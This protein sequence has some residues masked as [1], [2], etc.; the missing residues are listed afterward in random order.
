M[1]HLVEQKLLPRVCLTYAE[2]DL[3]LAR[4]YDKTG[5]EPKFLVRL[6]FEGN[7]TMPNGGRFHG[8]RGNFQVTRAGQIIRGVSGGI[9]PDSAGLDPGAKWDDDTQVTVE[10]PAFELAM[11]DTAAQIVHETNAPWKDAF[12]Y[13]YATWAHADNIVST[14]TDFISRTDKA[15]ADRFSKDGN[16]P[17]VVLPSHVEERVLN[18]ASSIPKEV[19][20]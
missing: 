7:A 10:A 16:P 4:A 19:F 5:L 6:R 20:R 17:R 13:L 14:D 1:R 15:F 9:P 8:I 18:L 2:C 11:F 3:S 12:H